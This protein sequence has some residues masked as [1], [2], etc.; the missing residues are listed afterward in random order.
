MKKNSILRTFSVFVLFCLLSL[1]L[2]ACSNT[3]N[4][5]NMTTVISRYEIEYEMDEL[6]EKSTLVVQGSV[7]NISDAFI[8]RGVGDLGELEYTDYSV[9]VKQV[10]RGENSDKSKVTVR[11]EGNPA[12]KSVIYEDD[13]TLELG[14]EYILFLEKDTAGGGF[15]TEGDYYYIVGF[16]YGVFELE[17]DKNTKKMLST[18]D[19]KTYFVS[20]KMLADSHSNDRK[21]LVQEAIDIADF[22][23]EE[24]TTEI[25]ELEA[26]SKVLV[27]AEYTKPVQEN[28][29][30]EEFKKNLK[31]NLDNGFISQEEY[32]ELIES[33][34]EYAVII[35]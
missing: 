15:D 12:D 22:V 17:M 19:N 28:M 29:R 7:T 33:L 3:E 25:I 16:K 27:D 5:A 18:D 31:I 9:D 14:N 35:G 32:D 1:T 23:K 10:L 8:I 4:T 13:P 6:I 30:S 24:V 20:Q 21:A 11:M 34:N 26:L 2:S